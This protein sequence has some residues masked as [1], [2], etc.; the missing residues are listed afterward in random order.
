MAESRLR[1]G[2]KKTKE[3]ARRDANM[4]TLLKKTKP[5]FAPQVNSWLSAKLNK[6]SRLVTADD[7]KK[8]VSPPADA[9]RKSGKTAGK[10]EK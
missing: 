9:R 4:I 2:V 3:R 10:V 5:P 1:N 8:L 6:P 7:I